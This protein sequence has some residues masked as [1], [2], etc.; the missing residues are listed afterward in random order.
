[1]S[2][3][4][5]HAGAALLAT[6]TALM[7]RPAA[8]AAPR[9]DLQ[10]I[11]AFTALN[12]DGAIPEDTPS[13][14]GAGR[15]AGTTVIGGTANSGMV[16]T[17]DGRTGAETPLY[18]FQGGRDGAQ[19]QAGVTAHGR[20]LFGT[21]YDGGGT[22]C[23][24]MGCGTVFRIDT[25]TGRE[26]V[27]HRFGGKGDGRV[28]SGGKL[29]Y[30]A[31]ALFGTTEFGGTSYVGTVYRV[32]PY[33]GATRILHSFSGGAEGR[34]PQGALILS[35]GLLYGTTFEGGG[36]GCH[37]A[38]GTVFS[39]DPASGATTTLH[40]FAT[41]GDAQYPFGSLAIQDGIIYGA[42]LYGGAQHH[43]AIFAFDTA[44]GA[45]KVLYSF[46]NN[47]D[48]AVPTG[49]TFASGA[50]YGGTLVG[51][52]S[53]LG[54]E[55]RVD[56]VTGKGSVVHQF[57]GGADGGLSYGAPVLFNG[58]LYGTTYQ[59]GDFN[60]CPDMGCGTIFKFRPR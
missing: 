44:A 22:G 40:A 55:W 12:G 5:L 35:G 13:A 17:L 21:T 18:S 30:A 19:P 58:A 36:H 2:A 60:S 10:T 25:A 46:T 39:V 16:Y 57:T 54:V 45:E 47:V 41:A 43:G 26:R 24:T 31:G 33:T 48:G 49:V 4:T 56:P 7:A 52:N 53:G 6:L 34:R 28:P 11:Y 27:L 59:G 29:V 15:L 3:T 42:S 37:H 32:D 23:H 51:G 50:L 20:F 1:M 14:I 38:C 8:A 9:D